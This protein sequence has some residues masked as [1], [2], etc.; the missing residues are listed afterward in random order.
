MEMVTVLRKTMFCQVYSGCGQQHEF[1]TRIFG[2]GEKIKV[3][4]SQ[5]TKK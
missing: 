5:I 1:S 3:C 4:I 2:D